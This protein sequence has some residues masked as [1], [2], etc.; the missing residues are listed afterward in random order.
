M[1]K[2][3]DTCGEK[4]TQSVLNFLQGGHM[5]K[6]TNHT[7]I[8]LIPKVDRP[9]SVNQFRLIS[10]CNSSY[11]ITAKCM[12]RRLQP[13]MPEVIRNFQSAFV[14]GRLINDNCIIA[15]EML[16]FVKSKKKGNNFS[17]ILNLDLNKAY[18]RV[19]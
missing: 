11:K 17:L 12:V 5:L 7:H 14:L 4:M 18:D 1:Q 9:D 6:E 16:S 2:H 19:R 3:W 13:I 8:A 15:H 10:L